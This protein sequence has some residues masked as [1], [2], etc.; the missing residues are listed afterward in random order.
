[1]KNHT[2]NTQTTLATLSRK[3]LAAS[4]SLLLVSCSATRPMTAAQGPTGPQDLHKYALLIQ[5]RPDGQ[6]THDWKSLSEFDLTKFQNTLSA[7]STH[8][9]IVRVSSEELNAYCDGRREQC[10]QDCFASSR[11]I[12]L[13]N[14]KY[15]DV[16][17][18]PWREAKRWW[19]PQ[20]CMKLADMCRR[21]MGPWAEEYAA[22]FDETDSAVDWLKTHRKEILT[23]TVIVIAG[24]A[25][26]AAV[27]ASGGGALVL[28]PLVLLTEN[29]PPWLPLPSLAEATR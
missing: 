11:P 2:E 21:S 27:A 22:E 3:I 13:W 7:V 26:V 6:V 8:Q 24:V 18:K 28:I 29:P 4:L 15:E 23:G 17:S 19:C 16:K 5:E 10:E 14:W 12:Q 1:M 20:H 9:G 25:F